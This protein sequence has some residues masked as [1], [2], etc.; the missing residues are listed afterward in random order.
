[1]RIKSKM[2]NNYK[3]MHENLPLNGLITDIGCGYGFM[4]YMLHFLEPE[5][6]ILGIDYDEEKIAV[7]NHCI[8]KNDNLEFKQNDVTSVTLQNSDA[9][10]LADVLHYLNEEDQKKLIRQCVDK[11]NPDG[12]IIIR[13]ADRNMKHKHLGTRI[14]EIFSTQL[15][16]NKTSTT[17]KE[18][19]FTSN[20]NILSILEPYNL[21]VEIIDQTRYT[22]NLIYIVRK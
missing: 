10:I 16:F 7:A 5:R 14:S 18:L 21:Q 2:E 12:T 13:D 3:L 22:S 9:F 15:G 11:L 6:S 20:E 8:S 17:R 1:M 19:F 4:D